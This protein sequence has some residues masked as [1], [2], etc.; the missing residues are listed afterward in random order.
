M[1]MT[2]KEKLDVAVAAF[3]SIL[4]S[5]GLLDEY[6]RYFKKDHPEV[7][8]APELYTWYDWARVTRREQWIASAFVWRDTDQGR[9]LWLNFNVTWNTWLKNNL[10]K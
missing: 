10:N 4:R 7:V 1:I 6:R 5:A 2:E 8:K 3:E 9:Y